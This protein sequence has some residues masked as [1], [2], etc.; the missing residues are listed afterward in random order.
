MAPSAAAALAF[1]GGFFGLHHWYLGRPVRGFLSFFFAGTMIPLLTSWIECAR[2]LFMDEDEFH[3]RYPRKHQMTSLESHMRNSL[4]QIGSVYE[5]LSDGR[6]NRHAFDADGRNTT[7]EHIT[8]WI[9]DLPAEIIE[10]LGPVIDIDKKGQFR[11]AKPQDLL[12]R[13]RTVHGHEVSSPKEEELGSE[14]FR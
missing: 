14:V 2:I 10:A 4:G 8:Q 13:L 11:R 12:D 7:P 6:L 1:L 3:R 5:M 9:S